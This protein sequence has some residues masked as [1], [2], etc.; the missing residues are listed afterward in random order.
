MFKT[1]II[2]ATLATADASRLKST[3][4]N[5]VSGFSAEYNEVAAAEEAGVDANSYS[6]SYG[7]QA[8]SYRGSYMNSSYGS[9]GYNYYSVTPGSK[10]SYSNYYRS[11][12]YGST[13]SKGESTVFNAANGK[14]SG[15][16]TYNFYYSPARSYSYSGSSYSSSYSSGSYTAS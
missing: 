9:V 12:S 15:N 11:P 3:M 8:Y 16:S 2:A 6:S 13:Y 5:K 4:T 14:K 7:Q 10:S 1:A